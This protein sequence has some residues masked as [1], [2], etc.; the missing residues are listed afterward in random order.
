MKN[1]P[2][3]KK[4]SFAIF[5]ILAVFYYYWLKNY[6]LQD[7]NTTEIP[8]S[9]FQTLVDSNK[10]SELN[11]TDKYIRGKFST[12]RADKKTFFQTNR[13]EPDLAR[14]LSKSSTSYTRI[15]ENNFFGNVSSWLFFILIF[16]GISFFIARRAADKGGLTGGLM[17]IGKSRAKLYVDTDVRSTFA[18]VAGVEEAKAELREVVDFLK[19]PDEYG[20]LGARMP[21]GI[22]L[23]GPPGTGK[24]LLAKSVAGEAHVPFFSISGS[25]FVEMFVGVGAAR[26]RDL[27]LQAKKA[28]P[29]IVFIDELDSLG[30]TRSGIVGGGLDEKEQTLNQLLAELDGFDT[31]S[32]IVILAATNRPE[33]LDPALLRSGR[34]DRQVLIDKPDKAGRE[35][36]LR[37]HI[38]RIKFDPEL[39]I[40]HIASLT[41]GFTGADLANLVNEAA[42]S[43]T[44]NHS[45]VVTEDNFTSAIERIV[46]GLEKKN[47][48]ISA[49]EKQ[50]IAYH[51]MGHTLVASAIPGSDKVH[52][53]SIISRG[54]GSLGYTIQRP[55]E[56][57]YLMTKQEL[58][59]KMAILLGGR[60][61]EVLIFNEIST[62]AADDLVKVTN[63]AEDIVTKYGMSKTMGPIVFEEM[64]NPFL[65]GIMPSNDQRPRS[66][67]SSKMIDREIKTIVEEAAEKALVILK[68]NRSVLEE[69]AKQLLDMETLGEEEIKKLIAKVQQNSFHQ[70]SVFSQH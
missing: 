18:D 67:E 37:V 27:F 26:V 31:K 23:V 35:A 41:P 46:A 69:G 33:T 10:V 48:I 11:I 24:T 70:E 8:Y 45:T 65:Q 20:R 52:K 2:L 42:L 66:D 60:M 30:R 61:A 5:I 19:N 62:G 64:R 7:F 47:R 51:E 63:I 49:K 29:C 6:S 32:G 40:E 54:I 57:R 43:A 1:M 39:N 16:Y 4:I 17:S 14:D 28:A 55:S 36:I 59:D 56:D 12:P 68:I 21:R 9:E 53:V 15:F 38:K 13:V 58:F 22:L 34:F 44:R 25:E 50:I 3:D